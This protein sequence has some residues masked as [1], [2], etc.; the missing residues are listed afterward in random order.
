MSEG[1]RRTV[2]R[3]PRLRPLL[4]AVLGCLAVFASLAGPPKAT[5][6]SAPAISVTPNEQLTHGQY[7]D[8]TWTG[9]G[10]RSSVKIRQCPKA[11][12]SAS[13]CAKRMTD[14][15]GPGDPRTGI[16]GDLG[17]GSIPFIVR[18]A[19]VTPASGADPFQ[20]DQVNECMIAVTEVPEGGTERPFEQSLTVALRYA[21]S[22]VPCPFGGDKIAGSGGSS[23]RGA[24]TEWQSEVCRDDIGLNVSFIVSNSVQGADAFAR[25]LPDSDY[26]VT[27]MPLSA[28]QREQ[29]ASRHITPRNVP[30]ILGSLVLV[31]NLWY[32][33]NGD[34]KKEQI[35]DLRLSPAT[36]A[37]MMQGRISTW[38]DPAIVADNPLKD[39]DKPLP[40]KQVKPVARADN[41]AA[42]FWLTTFLYETAREAYQAGGG[43]FQRPTAIFPAGNGV[44]L[45]TGTDAV[46]EYV[47][48]WPGEQPDESADVPLHGFIGYVYYSEALKLG[49]PVAA[50]RNASGNYVKP[51]PD[52]VTAAFNAGTLGS[53]AVF[54]PNFQT[55]DARAYPLPVTSYAV[56]PT[57]DDE[58]V[59][60]KKAETLG[61]F[62]TYAIGPGQQAAVTRGYVP[63]TAPMKSAAEANITEIAKQ[64]AA[65][66]APS[67]AATEA[68]PPAPAPTATPAAPAA[69]IGASSGSIQPGTDVEPEATP[70]PVVEPATASAPVATRTDPVTPASYSAPAASDTAEEQGSSV[71]PDAVEEAVETVRD[72]FTG[73]L[74]LA[75]VGSVPIGLPAAGLGALCAL[76]IGRMLINASRGDPFDARGELRSWL[77]APAKL[78]ETLRA[79]GPPP[80]RSFSR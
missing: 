1:F 5:G 78:I 40:V 14:D 30:L 60:A 39:G 69:T 75:G 66:L 53:D 73:V 16:S 44:I 9:F 21:I 33:R 36:I 11:A 52:N 68:A 58:G 61:R 38:D 76:F 63:L 3:C 6:Q 51:N 54:A 71:V 2:F 18:A 42:T 72:A 48:T 28:E 32:D 27:G 56:A 29:L 79:D 74:G 22:T 70:V 43:E 10:A 4:A 64:P 65:E 50:I 37:G 55:Q 12:T 45:R 26:T 19:D 59:D 25:G 34:G 49:L 24:M 77:H 7:V 80:P 47:R 15:P 17:S 20:C 62:L 35:T 57:G 46:A 23:A 41:S 67:Q 31:Y 13:Q 8:V